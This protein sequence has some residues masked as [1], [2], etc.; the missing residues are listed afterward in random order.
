MAWQIRISAKS[1]KT[2]EKL[3]PQARKRILLYLHTRVQA[4]ENP[5][6][7]G[8]P[9][10]GELTGFWRYRVDS[11]RVICEIK[12]QELVVLVIKIGHRKEIYA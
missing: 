8:K 9:L 11:Y 1:Q 3:N 2:L 10:R 5:K 6:L 7:L 12:D 4:L